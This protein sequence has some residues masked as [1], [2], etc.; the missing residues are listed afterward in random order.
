MREVD[1]LTLSERDVSLADVIALAHEAAKA[2]LLALQVQDLNGFD[3]HLE[4]QF[5]SSLDLGLVGVGNDDEA[6]L[7][8]L[9]GDHG[10][11]FRDHRGDEHLQKTFLV[12]ASISSISDTAAFVTTT[13]SK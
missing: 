3:L 5:N 9:L 8:Q 2:L 10:A 7:V 4:E 12:H 11:L 6:G 1:F 13:L